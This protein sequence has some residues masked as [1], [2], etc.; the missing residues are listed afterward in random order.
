MTFQ[1]ED[2]S[3][4]K[5]AQVI[6]NTERIVLNS[7]E[8]YLNFSNKG[9][10]FSTNGEFHVNTG[11]NFDS[12][13]FIVNAPQ[14]HLGLG[15]GETT[16]K[17]PAVKGNELEEIIL[18]LIKVIDFMYKIDLRLLN[19]ISGPPGTPTAPDPSWAN[20]TKANQNRLQDIKERVKAGEF[21]SK[22]V[23]LT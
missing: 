12:N 3:Q 9:F 4:F 1:P 8:D 6:T 10:H 7:K 22:K 19:P 17:N 18:E 20:K 14:I 23:F 2:I 5:G 16:E 21:Q 11:E 15:E 13:R